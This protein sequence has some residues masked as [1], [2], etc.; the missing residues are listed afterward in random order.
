MMQIQQSLFEDRNESGEIL[1]KLGIRVEYVTDAVIA[2]KIIFG[3]SD[4]TGPF[5]LDTETA[6]IEEYRNHPRAGLDPNLS[7]IRLVQIYPGG[8]SV[9]VFDMYRIN[10]RL[11]DQIWNFPLIAHN[12]VF[13]LKHLF[14]AGANPEKV[15]CTMLMENALSNNLR[16]LKGL[17]KKYLDLDLPKETALSDWNRREL[18]ENQISYAA[19]D[20]VIVHKLYHILKTKLKDRNQGGCYILMRDSQRAIAK[21]ELNGVHFDFESHERIITDWEKDHKRSETEL[22]R[23]LGHGVNPES[24]KQLSD[25]LKNNLD[26]ET[27]RNWPVSDTG[28]LRTDHWTLSRNS[29]QPFVKSLLDYKESGK[30]LSTYGRN[31]AEHR[32]PV[33]NRIHASFRLGGTISGRL[34]CNNPNI[35]NPP[36]DRLFRSLFSAPPGRVI[37][38]ADYGQIELRVA[39]LISGDREMLEAYKNGLDLHRITASAVAGVPLDKVT[40]E[41]R[42]AAKAINFGLLFG[43]GPTGLSLYAKSTYNVDMTVEEARN[44][45]Q[46]FFD[47]YR[48]LQQWQRDTSR[49]AEKTMRVRTPGGRVRD[50]NKEQTGYRFS[51]ALN[52]P[53]QGGAAEIMLSTLARLER[54][55]KGID[56]FPVNV[57]HDELVLEASIEDAEYAKSAVEKAMIEGMLSIFPRATTLNLVEAHIGKSWADAK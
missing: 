49:S 44:A 34:S 40:K 33:T 22:F 57:V 50:F 27:I 38:V 2:E 4:K 46:S 11:I 6:P 19:L 55:L 30:L 41:Q 52:T 47:K 23:L 54:N 14:L 16:S 25:W 7:K 3:L 31:F 35:Q 9:F 42:Q 15:G 21:M 1:K 37:V 36:R 10:M 39:A 18:T 29:D 8:D 51:E 17:A 48:G 43:Q 26:S 32:N 5:G 53:I 13:D 56:A 28:R 12:A 45:K 20:A 24:G